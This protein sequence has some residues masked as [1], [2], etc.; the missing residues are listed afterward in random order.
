MNFSK[1]DK[2]NVISV[3]SPYNGFMTKFPNWIFQ[4]FGIIFSV[5]YSNITLVR[6]M[7]KIAS[8]N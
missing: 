1:I 7:K 6:A 3:G 5:G 8:E 2:M 4:L